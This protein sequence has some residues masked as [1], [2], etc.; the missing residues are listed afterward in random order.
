[1][2]TEELKALWQKGFK[3]EGQTIDAEFQLAFDEA[4]NEIESLQDL[5]LE[6]NEAHD[7]YIDND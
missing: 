6:L 7:R 4:I 1:M 2:T 3:Y 5:I